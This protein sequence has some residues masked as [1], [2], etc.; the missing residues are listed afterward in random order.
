MSYGAEFGEV[1]GLEGLGILGGGGVGFSVDFW[2]SGVI[3]GMEMAAEWRG[4]NAGC[5]VDLGDEF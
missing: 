1:S 2:V 4:C 5:W 3:S